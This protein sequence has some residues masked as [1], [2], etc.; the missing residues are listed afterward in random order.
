MTHID[1]LKQIRSDAVTRMR[2]SDDYKLAARLGALIV[3]LGGSVDDHL[4]LAK[5]TLGSFASDTRVSPLRPFE[6]K[7]PVE[8]EISTDDM[9][10]ELAATMDEETTEPEASTSIFGV[11]KFEEKRA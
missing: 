4:N 1:Q 3:E 2:A 10:A 9:V 7:A 5:P 8:E 11:P 6:K